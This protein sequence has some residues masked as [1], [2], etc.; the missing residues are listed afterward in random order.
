MRPMP[1]L[2]AGSRSLRWNLTGGAPTMN[3]RDDRPTRAALAGRGKMIAA[4]EAAA[5]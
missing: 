5:R 2:P 4:L 3:E 1:V